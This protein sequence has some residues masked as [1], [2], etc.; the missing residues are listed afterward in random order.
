MVADT[1]PGIDERATWARIALVLLFAALVS[2]LVY[3]QILQ[4]RL[5][6]EAADENRIRALVRPAPR[7]IIRDREGRIVA[8]NRAIYAVEATLG[9]TSNRADTLAEL[10]AVSAGVDRE[11]LR[12]RLQE[13]VVQDPNPLGRRLP[14]P[15]RIVGD[16]K[17]PLVALV[18]E[19]AT[20]LPEI[21]V[22][23]KAKRYYRYGSLAGH[24][25]GYLGE[26]RR[27]ELHLPWAVGRYGPGELV[28]RSG[29]ERRY[30]ML[31]RGRDGVR[32]VEV[33]SHGREVRLLPNEEH[34]DPV[35]GMDV[36]L[37]LDLD[38][39]LLAD[40]LLADRAG[41]IV[42]LNPRDGDVLVL[43]SKPD[44][45]LNLFGRGEISSSDWAT[46]RDDPKT[47]MLHRA[48]AGLYP[49]AST[50]KLVM[51][52]LAFESGIIDR[53]TEFPAACTGGYQFGRR[54]FRCWFWGGH[55]QTD[56]LEA[57]ERSCD[58][59]YY[60][61]VQRF[62][63]DPLMSGARD[64]GFA[65]KTGIDIPG[66]KSGELPSTEWYDEHFGPKGWSRGILLNL[67]IGQG[68]ILVTPLQIAS[69]FGAV[70]AGGELAMPHLLKRAASADNRGVEK[71]PTISTRRLDLAQETLAILEEA[72]LRAVEGRKGTG[73]KA[74]VP[75]IE[76]G[77]K[78]GTAENPHG[79]THAWFVGVAPIGAPEI[80]AACIVEEGGHGG[81]TAA[82][83]VGRIL[84]Q[85]FEKS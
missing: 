14:R 18:E 63:L 77:G 34:R 16:A 51:S 76:V 41:A 81:A 2:R 59:F 9:M 84:R 4:H 33:D 55:G 11:F 78:T 29:A 65:S 69:F 22:R 24:A 15:V 46:I 3:L 61:L 71:V 1:S 85:Y 30:E 56:P 19:H 54:F 67:S 60:Q 53:S 8:E 36:F 32:V 82:P 26:I 12:R 68:E 40:S 21:D 49:P 75:G 45:D 57:F 44:Y 6:L 7:G 80:V 50:W 58:V 64:L 74:A 13:A 83:I 35:P 5:Y 31:L 66:E 79:E 42:A 28:G 10:I 25:I 17:L 62:Q 38:L 43:V 70:A 39:Q 52:A 73:E 27:D 23:I 37:T 20:K 48:I 72:L 47:P